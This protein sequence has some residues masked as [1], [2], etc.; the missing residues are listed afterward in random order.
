MLPKTRSFVWKKD[1]LLLLDQ[2]LLPHETYWRICR[3]WTQVA[4]GIRDMVV[5]GAPAIACTAAY[6]M[7]LAARAK[8]FRSIDDLRAALNVADKGLLHARPTAVNL[9]WALER[10][11]K[12]WDVTP[13]SR[14]ETLGSKKKYP[15]V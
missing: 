12:V 6:G 11:R 5:R 10:L 14:L 4:D 2:R 9:R 13:G 8:K 1:R 7:V 15:G 3:T